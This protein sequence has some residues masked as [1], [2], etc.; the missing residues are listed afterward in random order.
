MGHLKMNQSSQ[1][2]QPHCEFLASQ[3]NCFDIQ[4]FQSR[5]VLKKTVVLLV[6]SII[7][8]SKEIIHSTYVCFVVSADIGKSIW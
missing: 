7:V 6:I 4:K 8:M 1:V 5:M 2:D 3:S